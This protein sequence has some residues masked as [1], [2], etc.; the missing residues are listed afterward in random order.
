MDTISVVVVALTLPSPTA[1]V[2]KFAAA[3][4]LLQEAG[5]LKGRYMGWGGTVPGFSSY[6][7]VYFSIKES[8]LV[9]KRSQSCRRCLEG[10]RQ[11]GYLTGEF[12]I[13]LIV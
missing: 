5:T 8:C 1:G 13:V 2:Q 7:K 12:V 4:T 3:V 11:G 6:W 10:D 9:S